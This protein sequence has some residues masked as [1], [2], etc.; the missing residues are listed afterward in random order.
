MQAGAAPQLS[1]GSCSE[2]GKKCRSSGQ[3]VQQGYPASEQVEKVLQNT[4]DV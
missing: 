2:V 1:L 3:A 4:R